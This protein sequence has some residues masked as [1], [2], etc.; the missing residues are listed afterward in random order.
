MRPTLQSC[1][2]ASGKTA[3]AIRTR[4][5]GGR[6]RQL[7]FTPQIVEQRAQKCKIREVS[8]TLGHFFLRYSSGARHTIL[9]ASVCRVAPAP[10]GNGSLK[11]SDRHQKEN[12]KLVRVFRPS[13]LP[14]CMQPSRTERPHIVYHQRFDRIPPRVERRTLHAAHV[15]A[16]PHTGGM[17]HEHHAGRRVICR[18]TAPTPSPASKPILRTFIKRTGS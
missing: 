9:V 13:E 18:A 17:L 7:T 12:R 5:G 10:V 11:H 16:A 4:P 6:P 15:R 14:R 1:D 8:S 3:L 2:C